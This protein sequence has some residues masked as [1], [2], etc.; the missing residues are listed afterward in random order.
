MGWNWQGGK[1]RRE[2][3]KMAVLGETGRKV[4]ERVLGKGWLGEREEEEEEA[5]GWCWREWPLS[6]E[7]YR[8]E[9]KR[10][11]QN[12]RECVSKSEKR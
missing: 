12:E 4:I 10:Q 7:N 8:R 6:F 5:R 1:N 3:K 11:G 2:R 9:W